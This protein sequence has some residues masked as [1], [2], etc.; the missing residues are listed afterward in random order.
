MRR[1]HTTLWG[2]PSAIVRA[3]G[4]CRFRRPRRGG[5]FTLVEVV[6]VIVLLVILAGAAV[7][8]LN[9]LGE[10]RAATAA[11]L[12]LHDLSFARQRAQSTSVTAWVLID[13]AAE[14]WSILVE[15]PD[16][17]GRA[18]ASLLTD[19]ATGRP[20]IATLGT[21]QLNGVQIVSAVFDG[22]AE[23]GFDWL[24]RPRNA[25]EADLASDGVIVLTGNYQVQVEVETG[26][27]SLQSP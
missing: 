15:D 11:R 9:A 22:D 10:N 16:N 25:A 14:T 19:L 6:V 24:G 1:P 4:P 12:L 17:P 7:P 3:A 27:V 21:G 26:Y 18:D 2:D 20:Y 8:T 5:G 23:I 13:T